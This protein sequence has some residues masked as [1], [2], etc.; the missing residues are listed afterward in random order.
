M[1]YLIPNQS[2][3]KKK[4]K[5]KKKTAVTPYNKLLG[6]KGCHTYS[7]TIN[8]KM[9]ALTR[10]DVELAY[11]LTEVFHFSRNATVTPARTLFYIYDF[12]YQFK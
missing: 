2:L 9:N 8:S 3:L 5:K 12:K 1:S 6:N 7:K 4:K 10:V 11:L